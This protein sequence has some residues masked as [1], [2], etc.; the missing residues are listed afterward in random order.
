MRLDTNLNNYLSDTRSYREELEASGVSVDDTNIHEIRP[1]QIIHPKFKTSDRYQIL[2]LKFD[3]NVEIDE[4]Y[5]NE[6]DGY[7]VSLWKHDDEKGQNSDI[8]VNIDEKGVQRYNH[9]LLYAKHNNVPA[10][11]I[12]SKD[13]K[14]FNVGIDATSV[15][16]MDIMNKWSIQIHPNKI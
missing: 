11:N 5:F 6:Y 9:H 4:I 15:N 8:M 10:I 13:D 12:K 1:K 3:A 16:Y 14:S 7:N 2:E